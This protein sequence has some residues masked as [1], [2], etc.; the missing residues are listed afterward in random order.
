[1]K[2]YIIAKLKEGVDKYALVDPVT[3]IFK[4]TLAIPRIHGVKVKPCC[5]DR[6][7]RYDLMIEIEMERRLTETE[8]RSKSNTH[9]IDEVERRQ[10]NLEKLVTSVEVLATRIQTLETT[11]TEVRTDVRS[12]IAKPGKNWETFLWECG[13][14]LLAAVIGAVIAYVG[15]K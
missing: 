8:Q 12:L 11:M 14:L 15:L 2:H 13:K 4:K 3:E 7:N 1:M 10:D 9:R 5:I 6:P